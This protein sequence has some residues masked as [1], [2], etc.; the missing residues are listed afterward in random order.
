MSEP[1][2]GEIIPAGEKIKAQPIRFSQGVFDEICEQ[3]IM[4]NS[5]IS[6]CE[7]EDMPAKMSVLRWL[8][9][10]H[11]PEGVDFEAL[12]SQY[13]RA[14]EEQIE[15]MVDLMDDIAADGRNDWME[16]RDNKGELLGWRINGEH[17]ARSKL[18]IDTIKW[19]ASKLKPKK[20]GEKLDIV[21]DGKA[22]APNLE[23]AATRA[24]ALLAMAQRRK[25]EDE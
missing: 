22:L 12:R 4:G 3:I 2:V 21:S 15:T 24:A 7:R 10:M 6:I 18:R 17:V 11:L 14:R 23:D 8:N 16:Q 13:A 20:Y 25:Q 1:I 19:V 9:G 5:L